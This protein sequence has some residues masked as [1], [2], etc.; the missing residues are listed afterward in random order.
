MNLPLSIVDDSSFVKMLS[1]FNNRLKLPCRQTLSK[2][3]IPAKATEARTIL[4]NELNKIEHCS[5]TCDGWT[6]NGAHSYLGVT[7]HFVKEFSLKSYFLT[8]KH[9]K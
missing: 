8:L 9:L 3:L 4:Q 1:A 6:S 5:L 7:V 2:K